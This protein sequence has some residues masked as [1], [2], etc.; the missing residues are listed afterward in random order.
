M[1]RNFFAVWTRGFRS[2]QLCSIM[3]LRLDYKF[4]TR[5]SGDYMYGHKA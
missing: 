2:A 5:I 1:R 3:I 4:C